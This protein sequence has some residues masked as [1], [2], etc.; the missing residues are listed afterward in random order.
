MMD[1][2]MKTL[3]YNII[4]IKNIVLL[5]L[6]ALIWGVAFVAQ[7]VSMD[8]IQ[9]LT[10]IFLRS[11]IG[12][13]SL[14]PVI[15]IFDR[16]AQAGNAVYGKGKVSWWK[17]KAL[18]TGGIACGICFF[19]ANCCQQTG[20]QYTTVGKAGFITT[21]YIIIVPL[22]SL[23]LKRKCGVLTWISVCIALIGLYFL[24]INETLKIQQG[25]FLI[26]LSAVFF[27]LH[28]LVVD[29]FVQFNDGLKLSCIQFLIGALLAFLGMLIFEEP[30]L[31]LIL[32][33][34]API[35][36]TGLLSTGVGYTFQIIG[37]KGINPTIAALILS[38][39][40]V[41]SALSGFI[42]LHQVLS[43]REIIGCILMFAAIIIAQ[44]PDISSKKQE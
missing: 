34:A 43:I 23:F 41:F 8:F 3:Q 18:I 38:L 29:H 36:Y 42:I 4:K 21:F 44:L 2:L 25:D 6:T 32:Q 26:L 13:L 33:A 15:L 17:D 19:I 37:Q 12:G 14:I 9:P 40:S 31:Y 39:E 1:A 20:I 28:I 5:L 22:L 30:Q 24:C 11:L 35:L 10:F 16:K 27:A 7:S